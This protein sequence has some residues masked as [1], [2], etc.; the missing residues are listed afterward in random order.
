MPPRVHILSLDICGEAHDGP[1]RWCLTAADTESRLRGHRHRQHLRAWSG[2]QHKFLF[3]AQLCGP[4]EQL[5][6]KGEIQYFYE[7]DT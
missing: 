5:F 3:W 1:K 6:C 2:A 7:R 4:T